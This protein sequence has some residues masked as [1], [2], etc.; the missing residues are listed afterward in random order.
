MG[1]C[2]KIDNNSFHP[3]IKFTLEPENNNQL[4]FLDV[5]VTRDNNIFHTSVYRKPTFTGLGLNFYSF[6]PTFYKN[7]SCKTL[8][9]RAYKISSNYNNLHSEILVLRK[10]FKD[11]NYNSFNFE[12]LVNKY[13]WNIYR[14]KPVIFT[15]KKDIRYVKFPYIGTLSNKLTKQLQSVLQNKLPSLEFKIVFINP[16]KIGNLFNFKDKLCPLM[17]SLVV[18][19]F[20]CP[21]CNLGTYI[22]CTKR[23]LKVRIDEHR[24][25]SYGT[26]NLLK[27]PP[28]SNIRDHSNK[29]KLNINYS[30]FSILAQS[31]NIYE[32]NILESLF[33][34][35]YHPM[36]NKDQSSVPL[37]IV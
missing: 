25:L 3:R 14:P 4:P 37:Y 26:Q 19:K 8:I 24:G 16:L 34:K 11:N 33:I 5:L 22:G 15:V 10:Y 1:P 18:Y 30:D 20:T 32:L 28:F 13:L 17:R 6:C 35:Q 27:N 12:Y 23:L 7:N 29:C 36:L 31:N 9:D 2:Q 21:R